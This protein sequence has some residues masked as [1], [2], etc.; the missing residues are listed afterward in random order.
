MSRPAL[1]IVPL[2]VLA[3]VAAWRLMDNLSDVRSDGAA[4]RAAARDRHTWLISFLYIG[5][6]GSFI[7]Y[8]GAFAIIIKNQFPEVTLGLAFLGPLVGSVAR[9]FGGRLADR[10]GGALVSIGAFAT[11]AV[12]AG[13]AVVALQG[14]SFGLFFGSFLLLFVASGVGNGSTY[15]MIPAIFRRDVE[16]DDREGLVAAKR[17]AAACIGISAGIGAYGGF[18]IPRGF[19][20]STTQLGSLVPAL[21]V[22]IGFYVVCIV[23]VAA[24]YARRGALGTTERI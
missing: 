21:A 5:T 18:L 6:F 19:A 7:G 23:I 16:P 17:R 1:A 10:A 3:A 24:V 2:A 15:R 12:G 20:L 4:W 11:M 14:Q 9:P 13:I 22:F 8:S